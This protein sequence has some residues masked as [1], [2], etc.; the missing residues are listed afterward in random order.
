MNSNIENLNIIKGIK[1]TGIEA[2]SAV[3]GRMSIFGPIIE[4]SEAAI[5]LRNGKPNHLY[6][7]L[8]ELIL[9]GSNGCNNTLNIIIY[10]L[11][12]K[13]IPIL[14][15]EYPETKNDIINLIDEINNFLKYLDEYEIGKTNKKYLKKYQL[16][17]E[18][19]K[20]DYLEVNKII[21][22]SLK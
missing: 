14:E 16:E 20:E 2:P 22:D 6:N 4:E 12:E 5:I 1:Y 19:N 10:L 7:A 8:N 13:K 3:Q 11:R 17:K 21:K 9:F 15:L 18:K